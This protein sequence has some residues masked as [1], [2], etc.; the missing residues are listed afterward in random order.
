MLFAQHVG[1]G[2]AGE[3]DVE[4]APRCAAVGVQRHAPPAVRRRPG[5]IAGADVGG[6]RDDSDRPLQDAASGRPVASRMAIAWPCD[7]SVV[8]GSPAPGSAHC[9]ADFVLQHAGQRAREIAELAVDAPQADAFLLPHARS[10]A[11]QAQHDQ[12]RERIPHR[13]PRAQRQRRHRAAPSGHAAG[14]LRRGACESTNRD[15]ADRACAAA[16][17]RRRRRRSTADRSARPRRAR[18]CRRG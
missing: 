12:Q 4:V 8:D 15:P 11:E 1:E 13:Q 14:S 6:S 9:L 10:S 2:R 17:A 7:P 3:E 16:A 18:R 5:L